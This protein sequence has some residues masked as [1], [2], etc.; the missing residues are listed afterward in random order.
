MSVP[1]MS[2]P[3]DKMDLKDGVMKICQELNIESY[4]NTIDQ[5]RYKNDT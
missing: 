3:E 2:G 5:T 4:N 1:L